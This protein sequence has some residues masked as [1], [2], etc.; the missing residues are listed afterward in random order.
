MN[1]SLCVCIYIYISVAY[2]C[3][4]GLG[5]QMLWNPKGSPF[6]FFNQR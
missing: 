3:F 5:G 2:K 1:I 4:D 6:V